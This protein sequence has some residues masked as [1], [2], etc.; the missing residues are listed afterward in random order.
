M[1][2]LLDYT[3]M[4]VACPL[5]ELFA[6]PLPV[7][8]TLAGFFPVS[9]EKVTEMVFEEVLKYTCES[10]PVKGLEAKLL[11]SPWTASHSYKRTYPRKAQPRQSTCFTTF[12]F[13]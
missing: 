2:E 3:C 6:Y 12:L 5:S 4:L 13:L 11:A 9:S 1:P 7:P 10:S 8:S